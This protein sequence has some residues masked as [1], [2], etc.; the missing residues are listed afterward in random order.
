MPRPPGGT[1]QDVARRS[2]DVLPGAE[3]H[4]GVE[5]ALN[6]AVA[7]TSVPALVERDPPVEPDHV[8]TRRAITGSS[9]DAPVPK[10]IV[11]TSNRCATTA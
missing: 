7:A 5:V 6:A 8:A 1:A 10:W 3:Q 11:G 4:S 2:F 9:V